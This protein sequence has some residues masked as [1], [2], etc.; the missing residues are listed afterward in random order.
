MGFVL[1]LV[2]DLSGTNTPDNLFKARSKK[3]E[4]LKKKILSGLFQPGGRS[5]L[6][7]IYFMTLL[8]GPV[9]F[10][11]VAVCRLFPHTGEIRLRYG[12][13]KS[14][15]KVYA[16]YVLNPLLVLLRKHQR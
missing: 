3:Y 15:K 2:N 9:E 7:M 13:N 6:R 16:Y 1:M 8:D 5:H 4:R 14:S 11:R 10:A 12:L